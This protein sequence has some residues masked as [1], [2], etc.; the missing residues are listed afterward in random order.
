MLVVQTP[1]AQIGQRGEEIIVSVKGEDARK[2]PGQQVRAIYCYGAVQMTAQAVETCLELGIDVAY[3]SPAGR[4]LGVLRGLPASGVDA[5]RGQYRLFELPGVRMQLAREVIRAKIHNQ[6]VMLMRNGEVPERVLQLMAEFPRRHCVGPRFDGVAG[7]R[8]QRGGAVLRA[9][10]VDA[11]T[12]RG[13]EVR[14]ARAQPP[15]A[16]RSGQRAVV[17][18]LFDAGEGTDGRVPCGGT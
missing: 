6:R 1:G 18:G 3:F 13:L 2:I 11:E 10:R 7:H 5:R 14:L 17:A 16:A 12:A 15:S 4:F 8:G 9:V